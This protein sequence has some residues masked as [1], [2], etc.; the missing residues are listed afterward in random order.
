MT[1]IVPTIGRVVHYR[2]ASIGAAN[3]MQVYDVEKPLTALVVFVWSD[4]CVNLT[5]FD[6]AGNAHS[7]SSVPI[8]ETHGASA[9]A[10]WMVYQQ[11]QAAKAEKAEEALARATAGGP[12]PGDVA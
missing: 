5:V 11:G 12:Q 8:N 2:G 3:G 4:T 6:H 1:K 7:R 10:E 9:W